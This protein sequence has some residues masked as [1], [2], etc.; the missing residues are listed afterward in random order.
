M[1]IRRPLCLVCIVFLCLV[2]LFMKGEPPSPSWDVDSFSGR[3]LSLSGKI[4]DKQLKNDVLSVYLTDVH[5]YRNTLLTGRDKKDFPEKAKGVVVKLSDYSNVEKYIRLGAYLEVRGIFT[6]F[7]KPM[8]E[9]QFDARSYYMIR[10]YEGQIKRAKVTGVSSDYS[11]FSESLRNFR[12]RAFGIIGTYLS[13]EDAGLLAAMT[14]GDKTGLDTEIKE[15][16]QN[17][18]IS[19]VLALSGLHIAS[20]GL[21]LLKILRKIGVRQSIAATISGS[22]IVIYGIMTGMSTSTLR[23]M[24]MFALAIIAMLIGR[25]YDLLSAAA[26]SAILIVI[27]NPGYLFDSGFLLSFGAI[28]GIGCVF[29]TIH[30][31]GTHGTGTEILPCHGTGTEILP[32]R[33]RGHLFRQKSHGKKDRLKEKSQVSND[34]RKSIETNKEDSRIV[35]KIK[36]TISAA[37]QGICVSLSVTIVTL[38]VMAYSFFQVSRYQA[39]LNLVVIPFMSIVLATGFAGVAL[40]MLAEALNWQ[41]FKLFAVILFKI[42][43]VILEIYQKLCLLSTNFDSNLQIYGRPTK[44]H[45]V[46]YIILTLTGLFLGRC[47]I[48]NKNNRVKTNSIDRTSQKNNTI[49]RKIL[50]LSAVILLVSAGF[51]LRIHPKQDLEVRNVFVGQGDCSI[52][53]GKNTPV[54]IVDGGS[55]D[56]KQ[57]GKYRIL[58]VLKANGISTVDYCFL[59]HM[60]DDHING[61]IEILEDATCGVKVRNIIISKAAWDKGSGT[62]GTGTEIMSDS[63]GTGTEIMS[64]SAEK[65]ENYENSDNFG[66]LITAIKSSGAKLCLIEAGDN[67]ILGDLKIVCINP[68]EAYYCDEN[69]SSIVLSIKHIPSDFDMMFTGDV[70]AETEL[71]LV[72]SLE[73]HTEVLNCD[74][75]KVAHHGSRNSSSEAFLNAVSPQIS[76]ISAGIDNERTT[77][78]IQA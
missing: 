26:L 46:V 53:C 2:Y 58:P 51:S 21:A 17:A 16:Y 29:P 6:P 76:V 23:A 60:D 13:E 14:L 65:N 78:M 70:S 47:C 74:F 25:T 31:M 3:T 67:F 50:C 28:V 22:I 59:T 68:G 4:T 57:V 71:K 5:I 30:G 37:Y 9:G 48:F 36:K 45:V 73:N 11:Y 54:I 39:L 33:Q 7:D 56:T 1:K 43:E 10:G 18:G 69:D 19:H 72:K 40:G 75:L 55:T 66:K 12:E 52:I 24:I 61:I 41:I 15:L 20:V 77:K 35:K 62:H 32:C 44:L 63:H 49:R 27:E 64:D 8:N 34:I 42:T 38:P